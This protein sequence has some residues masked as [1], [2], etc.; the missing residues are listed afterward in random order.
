MTIKHTT[1]LAL[2]LLL[3]GSLLTSAWAGQP[4]SKI[5]KDE[6]KA[7]LFDAQTYVLDVRSGRDWSSSEF[8]I[9]GA[10]RS[11]PGAWADWSSAYPKTATLVLYCA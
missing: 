5:S 9:K 2:A 7:R 8:K 10:H 6:L 11:D 4:V 1:Y 3:V